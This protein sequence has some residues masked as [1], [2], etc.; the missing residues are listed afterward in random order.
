LKTVTK[1]SG[2][3]VFQDICTRCGTRGP[4]STRSIGATWLSSEES[5][6]NV[7]QSDGSIERVCHLCFWHPKKEK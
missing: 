1:P 6:R 2:K 3:R 5:W 7:R 4:E